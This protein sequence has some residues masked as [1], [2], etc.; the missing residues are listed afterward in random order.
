MKT[1]ATLTLLAALS[2]PA[3][4]HAEPKYEY[5]QFDVSVKGYQ[6]STW[7]KSHVAGEGCDLNAQGSGREV[8]RFRSKKVRIAASWY[9]GIAGP[10]LLQKGGKVGGRRG[11]PLRTRITRTGTLDQWGVPCSS[12]SGTGAAETPQDCGT[13][14]SDRLRA[15]LAYDPAKPTSLGL[16]DDF[17]WSPDVF[18][19]CP[20]GPMM[21]PKVAVRRPDGTRLGRRLPFRDLFHGPQQHI[22]R[23]GATFDN[24]I[25]EGTSST[26]VGW[27]VTITRVKK[28]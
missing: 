26:E 3:V 18:E 1:I 23:M 12:G 19:N 6:I 20:G 4:A 2:A 24:P 17:S 16:S 22:L 11:I 9:P 15:L 27:E 21:F 28:R 13:R 7:T 14:H 10:L 25:Y 5:A 8:M